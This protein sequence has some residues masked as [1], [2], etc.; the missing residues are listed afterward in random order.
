MYMYFQVMSYIVCKFSC[1]HFRRFKYE[2]CKI[3]CFVDI[4]EIDKMAV[5]LHYEILMF[6]SGLKCP[7]LLVLTGFVFVVSRRLFLEVI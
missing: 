5:I 3:E 7:M 4:P 1:F 2:C 6:V